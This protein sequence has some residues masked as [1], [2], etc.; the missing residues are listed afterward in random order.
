MRA[1]AAATW[2]RE[3]VAGSSVSQYGV[4]WRKTYGLSAYRSTSWTDGASKQAHCRGD[5]DV[6]G[7]V[8]EPQWGVHDHPAADMPSK[9]GGDLGNQVIVVGVLSSGGDQPGEVMRL[10][11]DQRFG[12]PSELRPV[13]VVEEVQMFGGG[14]AGRYGCAV[15][16]P[17]LLHRSRESLI[18]CSRESMTPGCCAPCPGSPSPCGRG[19]ER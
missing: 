14:A 13:L 18:P 16:R 9:R 12:F 17:P 1:R 11:L 15:L 3:P 2:S 4:P 19:P 8:T 6:V 5:R 10:L 7:M